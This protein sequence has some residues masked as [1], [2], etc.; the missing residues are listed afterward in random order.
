M[1]AL[2]LFS[3]IGGLDL[4]AEMA[5]IETAAFC[6][7]EPFAV[8][9]LERRFPGVPIFNDVRTLTAR[10]LKSKGLM[11]IDVVHGGFPCQDVSTSGKRT[12]FVNSDGQLTR[13]GLWGEMCRIVGEVKPRWV[14]AENVWGL[15]S[16]PS[17]DG[18][19][20]GG[21]GIVL[22][23]LAEMGY[24]AGWACYG[25]SDVGAIHTR[26]RVAV[27]AYSS[28]VRWRGLDQMQQEGLPVF[29]IQN[30]RRWAFNKGYLPFDIKGL[31]HKPKRGILRNDDGLSE[32]MDRLK[33]LGNAVVPQ[34]FYPVF[35][36]IAEI[37]KMIKE[38]A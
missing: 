19:T 16:I 7:I 2:S 12:G 34:Q 20:G 36:A 26:N 11:P 8:K 10:G 14:V 3:G 29:R 5:G 27:V 23:D 21:Y 17:P 31:F 28:S 22:R 24:R 33:S 1:K 6:E 30:G 37:E 25:A 32:G 4:A 13:S 38:A 15:L 35:K 9:V 18:R